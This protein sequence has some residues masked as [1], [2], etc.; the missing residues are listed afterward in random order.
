M[1]RAIKFS[2]AIASMLLV[3]EIVFRWLIRAVLEP[4]STVHLFA[5]VYLA[6][7]K[8]MNSTMAFGLG[9]VAW[10]VITIVV[11]LLFFV[12]GFVALQFMSLTKNDC[13]AKVGCA[14][15]F[16]VLSV[17][18]TNL[19][20]AV[21]LGGV[22]D[23]LAFVD[24]ASGRATVINFGDVALTFGLAGLVISAVG[25]GVSLIMRVRWSAT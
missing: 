19:L 17:A 9:S 6:N 2:L 4:G 25:L 11:I 10:L 21:F 13:F 22:T 1:P 16:V 5:G 20:E 23:Y 8:N 15:S 12:S 24:L 3:F 7:A 14:C 18:V